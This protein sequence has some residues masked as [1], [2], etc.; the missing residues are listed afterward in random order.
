MDM[1]EFV[2]KS[3]INTGLLR[4]ENNSLI[5]YNEFAMKGIVKVFEINFVNWLK[6]SYALGSHSTKGDVLELFL[7]FSFERKTNQ[8]ITLQCT[9][10]KGGNAKILKLRME[11]LQPISKSELDDDEFLSIS[12]L[13][14]MHTFY[15]K[16]RRA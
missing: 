15:P 11:K 6:Q 7:W 3:L 13:L 12:G 1:N 9:D 5:A 14:Q 16:L 8:T 10:L 2:K 4:E